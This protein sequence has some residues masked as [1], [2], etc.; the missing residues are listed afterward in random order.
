MGNVQVCLDLPE[1]LARRLDPSGTDVA[2]RIL[3]ALVIQLVQQDAISS[4][5]GAELLGILK[6]DFRRLLR[7]RGVSYMDLSEE[8]FLA[9]L[10]AAAAYEVRDP[11]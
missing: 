9:D 1:E 7:Q 2:G 3:E 10:E 4:G 6:R 8:E 5:K 11:S